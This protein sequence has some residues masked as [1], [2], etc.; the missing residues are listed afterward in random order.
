M[1]LPNT[2]HPI[3]CY[4]IKLLSNIQTQNAVICLILKTCEPT[5][6]P[7]SQHT[8]TS[9]SARMQR[10][11]QAANSQNL[12]TEFDVRMMCH[13]FFSLTE[14]VLNL[15]FGIFAH[16]MFVST[17]TSTFKTVITRGKLCFKESS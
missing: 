1:C 9:I 10:W 6:P 5:E 13:V 12:H 14:S 4:V 11:G 7:H 2:I 15:P 3:M 17:H 8:I 16:P